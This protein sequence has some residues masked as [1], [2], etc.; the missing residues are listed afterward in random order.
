MLEMASTFESRG[1]AMSTDTIRDAAIPRMLAD[2]RAFADNSDAF[3]LTGVSETATEL[4]LLF[5]LHVHYLSRSLSGATGVAPGPLR[6]VIRIGPD[7]LRF[8][9]PLN[10]VQVQNVDA[11]H[12]NLKW[13]VLCVG[14]LRPGMPLPILLR[15]IY[16][17]LTYQNVSTSDGLDMEA[18]LLLQ[19]DPGLVN[20]LPKP[21]RLQ[22]PGPAAPGEGDSK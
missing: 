17:I 9:E 14:S 3:E 5:L 15:H 7:Y 21:P 10:T 6:V 22:R 12:P 19:R 18:C 11:L 20:Q 16:E 1:E 2:A 8:G 13:P 4:F